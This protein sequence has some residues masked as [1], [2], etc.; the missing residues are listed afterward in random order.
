MLENGAI[1]PTKVHSHGPDASVIERAKAR[2]EMKRRVVETGETVSDI[3]TQAEAGMSRAAR[4]ETPRAS[5]T[6]RNVRRHRSNARGVAAQ[7]QTAGEGELTVGYQ[8]HWT[9]G[10]PAGKLPPLR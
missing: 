9:A 5:D 1:T 2:A 7:P 4:A 3:C 8:L 6:Y 10:M